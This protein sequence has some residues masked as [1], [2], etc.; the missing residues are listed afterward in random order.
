M[1]LSIQL[2]LWLHLR[3][4]RKRNFTQSDTAWIGAYKGLV[5]RIVFVA[6]ATVAPV[7]V[8]VFLLFFQR[9]LPFPHRAI[10][11]AALALTVT[12]GGLCWYEYKRTSFTAVL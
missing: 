2:Y 12:F 3:E 7:G 8:L 5:P 6:T 4:Y 1:V 9:E 11:D 10:L